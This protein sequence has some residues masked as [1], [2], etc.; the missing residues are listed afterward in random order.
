VQT[1]EDLLAAG[2]K[3]TA[4][5]SGQFQLIA[6]SCRDCHVKYRD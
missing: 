4:R 3:D 2:A 6:A 1:L 5:L